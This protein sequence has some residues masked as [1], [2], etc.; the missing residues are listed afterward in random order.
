MDMLEGAMLKSCGHIPRDWRDEHSTYV[1]LSKTTN[2]CHALWNLSSQDGGKT[3][4]IA[5]ATN[6]FAQ[7]TNPLSFFG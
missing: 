2:P 7:I 6:D 3:Y 5:V 1:I 4:K